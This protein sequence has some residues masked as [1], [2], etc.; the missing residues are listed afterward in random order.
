[1]SWFTTPCTYGLVFGIC[2]DHKCN[3]EKFSFKNMAN[4]DL[5]NKFSD[6]PVNSHMFIH[7]EDVLIGAELSLNPVTRCSK[8]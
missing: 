5:K 2:L 6:D 3:D 1:M 4:D 8:P 7:L